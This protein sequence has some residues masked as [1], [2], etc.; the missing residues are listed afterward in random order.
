MDDKKPINW[1]KAQEVT[2]SVRYSGQASNFVTIGRPG[3]HDVAVGN[4]N[5]IAARGDLQLL[6]I[7]LPEFIEICLSEIEGSVP[8]GSLRSVLEN[9]RGHF[10]T[11][12]SELFKGMQV[13]K[14]GGGIAGD[15]Y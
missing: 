12:T 3:F 11:E 4:A 7:T 1:S 13:H 2:S 6:L 9:A 5:E 10:V 8:A 15:K 14:E